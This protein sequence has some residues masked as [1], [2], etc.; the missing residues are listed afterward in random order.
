MLGVTLGLGE[1]QRLQPP[2]SFPLPQQGPLDEVQKVTGQFQDIATRAWKKHNLVDIWVFSS[3]VPGIIGRHTGVFCVS[4]PFLFISRLHYFLGK[5]KKQNQPTKKTT[6]IF[7]SAQHRQKHLLCCPLRS[8]TKALNLNY[9]L[10]P[11][12]HFT[13]CP[14]GEEGREQLVCPVGLDVIVWGEPTNTCGDDFKSSHQNYAGDSF[15]LLLQFSKHFQ[16]M[17]FD[18]QVWPS[19][20]GYQEWIRDRLW[21]G[22]ACRLWG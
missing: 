4:S 17:S 14:Q 6:L 16:L 22:S 2:P 20:L 7:L 13:W 5:S 11:S 19:Q 1:E 12:L 21:H 3:H 9:P 15:S 18:P 8:P 10:L